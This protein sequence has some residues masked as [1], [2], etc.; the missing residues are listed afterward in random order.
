MTE[1]GTNFQALFPS[2]P[3]QYVFTFPSVS[4]TEGQIK[5]QVSFILCFT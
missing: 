4:L 5:H 1:P 3:S 2:A